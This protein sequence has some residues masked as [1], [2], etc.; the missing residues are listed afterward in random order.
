MARPIGK[1]RKYIV[2]CIFDLYMYETLLQEYGVPTP[3]M[4]L[5]NE[6]ESLS[7]SCQDADDGPLYVQIGPAA[8]YKGNQGETKSSSS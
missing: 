1:L 2:F 7:I 4:G 6:M 8:H 5:V 3:S